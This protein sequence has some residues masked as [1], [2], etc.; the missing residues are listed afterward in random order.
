MVLDIPLFPGYEGL[1]EQIEQFLQVGFIT[2]GETRFGDMP[3]AYI[4]YGEEFFG[5][6]ETDRFVVEVLDRIRGKR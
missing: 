5:K 1:K 6:P 4:Y 3:G 2:R